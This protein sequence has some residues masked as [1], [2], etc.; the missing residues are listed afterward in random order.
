[1]VIRAAGNMFTI[2]GDMEINIHTFLTTALT[3]GEE[4][5][6]LTSAALILEEF[7]PGTRKIEWDRGRASGTGLEQSQCIW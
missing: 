6:L 7:A 2:T 1:V 5:Q 3:E 4:S